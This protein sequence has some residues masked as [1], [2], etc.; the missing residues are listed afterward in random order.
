MVMLTFIGGGV[1]ANDPTWIE[2]AI[3][4]ACVALD[5]VGLRVIICHFRRVNP[6]TVRRLDAAIAAERQ[7]VATRRAVE[8]SA[9]NNNDA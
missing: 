2:Q 6:E 9:T 5:D 4:R 3:A 7:R 8:G 1:F